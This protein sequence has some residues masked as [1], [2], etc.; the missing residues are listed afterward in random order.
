MKKS[1][2]TNRATKK[3][4]RV[5]K[6]IEEFGKRFERVAEESAQKAREIILT[7]GKA[8]ISNDDD[9][10][11][12][13]GTELAEYITV[14]RLGKYTFKWE[15]VAG[16]YADDEIKYELYY[17]NYGAGIL[18]APLSRTKYSGYIPH[19]TQKNGFWYYNLL[20]G[21]T[22]IKTQGVHAGEPTNVGRTNRSKPLLFMTEARKYA[23]EQLGHNVKDL[24]TSIIRIWNTKR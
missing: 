4:N 18:S 16:A 24:K 14:N 13:H 22:V 9:F 23:K 10:T 5:Q 3:L 2:V 12:K 1:R 17:A 7:E 15:I 20:P 11:Q 8:P 21:Q 6:E 19:A